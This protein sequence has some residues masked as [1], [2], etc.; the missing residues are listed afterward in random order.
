MY[1][2]N[3]NTLSFMRKIITHLL[4]LCT[5]CAYSQENY[6]LQ[7]LTAAMKSRMIKA[8]AQLTVTNG[9]FTESE[10]TVEFTLGY[11]GTSSGY[12]SDDGVFL[13]PE[14]PELWNN[15]GYFTILDTPVQVT[16]RQETL[17]TGSKALSYI[18]FNSGSSRW[19]FHTIEN[20]HPESL[21]KS[22]NQILIAYGDRNCA[23]MILSCDFYDISNG[24]ER[25]V[26]KGYKPWMD[27]Y[28]NR[29]LL[30]TFFDNMYKYYH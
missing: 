19:G 1:I 30:R 21:Q 18:F 22:E 13:L 5:L 17:P 23:F 28:I 8:S 12:S 26:L 10:V 14:D 3:L 4:L 11:G 15:K 7:Q 25:L 24:T 29:N 20:L 27:E 2:N 9:D 6:S 16:K